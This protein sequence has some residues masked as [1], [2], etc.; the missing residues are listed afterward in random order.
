MTRPPRPPNSDNG[1]CPTVISGAATGSSPAFLFASL[2]Q[3]DPFPFD[4]LSRM[5]HGK[6][7]EVVLS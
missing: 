5:A 7:F 3:V 2:G 6:K 1:L 4:M